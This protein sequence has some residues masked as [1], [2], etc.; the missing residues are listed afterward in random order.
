[1]RGGRLDVGRRPESKAVCE[2]TFFHRIIILGATNAKRQ[3]TV[4][5]ENGHTQAKETIAEDAAQKEKPV[6]KQNSRSTRSGP[7]PLQG[8]GMPRPCAGGSVPITNQPY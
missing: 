4:T 1:M 2:S 5:P 3:K 7:G 6:A 8:R